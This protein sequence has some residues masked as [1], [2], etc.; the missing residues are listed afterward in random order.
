MICKSTKRRQANEN[1]PLSGSAAIV[2][3]MIIL[4]ICVSDFIITKAAS[5]CLV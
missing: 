3:N 4:P 2:Y 1:L 5:Q